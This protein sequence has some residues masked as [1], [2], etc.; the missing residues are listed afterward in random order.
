MKWLLLLVAGALT[1]PLYMSR[2]IEFEVDPQVFSNCDLP[3]NVST[4]RWNV[5]RESVQS[6]RVFVNSVNTPENLWASGEPQGEMKTGPWV[7]DGLTFTLR[8][9]AGEVLAKRTVQT[10]R[11]L[12]NNAGQ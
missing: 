12:A 6:V 4:V 8:D 9:Q 2:G 10:T 7:A 5:A 3:A 1:L 11:C